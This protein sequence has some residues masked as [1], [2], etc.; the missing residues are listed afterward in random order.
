MANVALE[1]PVPYIGKN[2]ERKH[3]EE[4]FRYHREPDEVVIALFDGIVF[5]GDGKRVGGLTLHDYV[6]LTDQHF[7]L[8]ARGLQ[9][10]VLDRLDY[11]GVRLSAKAADTLHGELA[12]EF[13]PPAVPKA[14]TARVDLLPIMDLPALGE[15]FELTKALATW[16][17]GQ[18][19]KPKAAQPL[20]ASATAAGPVTLP[21]EIVARI[22]RIRAIVQEAH[23]KR[24][25]PFKAPTPAPTAHP[26]PPQE[27][28]TKEPSL[29][30]PFGT[31]RPVSNTS[32]A[33]YRV[34]QAAKDAIGTFPTDLGKSIG[35]DETLS[36]LVDRI[37]KVEDIG[38]I[39]ALIE[40]LNKL[41]ITVSENPAARAFLLQAID[42]MVEQGSPF[43][44]LLAFIQNAGKP[45]PTPAT[46]APSPAP[47]TEPATVDG[48]G[49]MAGAAAARRTA[50]KVSFAK[51]SSPPVTDDGAPRPPLA[52]AYGPKVTEQSTSQLETPE[53]SSAAP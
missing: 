17:A 22:E 53:L 47:P 28:A 23:A 30:S 33:V 5:D 15:L 43:K 24:G 21:D 52:I 48:T 38:Q 44:Q 12:L 37:P 9:S 51:D 19:D 25:T 42:R 3:V 14:L 7:I 27:A 1:L 11:R 45:A 4:F 13:T 36:K 10:D 26:V 20:G 35:L 34:A 46:P 32:Y 41:L 2:V 31:G 6:I 18:S 50:V 39:T 16:N 49:Q 8:W 29:D 40:A